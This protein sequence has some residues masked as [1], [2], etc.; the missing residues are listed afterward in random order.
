[1][2]ETDGAG[3]SG[4]TQSPFDHNDARKPGDRQAAIYH[5]T[6]EVRD[7]R[8]EAQKQSWQMSGLDD[9]NSETPVVRR[10]LRQ[11]YGYWIR[12]AGVD[13]FRIDTALYV[14]REALDDFLNA[15]DVQAPGVLRVA[16][17]S[18][19]PSF[20]VFGEG[21][22]IDKP[23]ED[24]Q[25][26]RIDRLMQRDDGTPAISHLQRV[27]RPG[28]RVYR[29]ATAIRPV[30]NGLGVGIISTSQGLLTDSQARER[31]L[32]GEVVCEIW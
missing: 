15:E 16:K 24:S 14:P 29:G 31:A 3:N 12:E 10:A 4:P 30:L 2:L 25:A 13:G 9:L 11:S 7:F 22:A 19:K 5:W 21:F 17:A 1:M 27:S 26:R 28:R 18:G 20:H 6:P 23:Y 32:G 8:D